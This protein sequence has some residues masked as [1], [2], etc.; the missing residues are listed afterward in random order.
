MMD[1][2][3]E[4]EGAQY[5]LQAGDENERVVVATLRA[6]PARSAVL[7]LPLRRPPLQSHP[8]PRPGR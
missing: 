1:R 7:R 4:A 2:S 5:G 6:A 8:L 3:D